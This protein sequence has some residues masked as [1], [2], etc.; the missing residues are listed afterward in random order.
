MANANNVKV[1]RVIE[2]LCEG[3]YWVITS[4]ELPG[5]LLSGKDLDVLRNS[6]PDTIEKLMRLNSRIEVEVIK[7]DVSY[8]ESAEHPTTN[9]AAVPS[10]LQAVG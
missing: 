3:R 5:F 6:I 1:I 8:C 9:W 4:P 10:E 2:K 7:A